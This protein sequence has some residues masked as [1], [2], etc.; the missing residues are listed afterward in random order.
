MMFLNNGTS[1]AVGDRCGSLLRCNRWLCRY[2]GLQG[3]GDE[4]CRLVVQT[5]VLGSDRTGI[6]ICTHI[7]ISAYYFCILKY[8][9]PF[10]AFTADILLALDL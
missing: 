6:C 2:C 1:V 3:N 7:A 8:Y 9:A 5:M 10:S 4:C